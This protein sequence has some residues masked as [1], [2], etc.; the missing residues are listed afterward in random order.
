MQGKSRQKI[1]LLSISLV[2][3]LCWELRSLQ[4]APDPINW[5]IYYVRYTFFSSV[6]KNWAKFTANAHP[7][8][9]VTLGM[10]WLQLTAP[11]KCRRLPLDCMSGAE[12][13]RMVS[14]HILA[15]AWQTTSVT[16]CQHSGIIF[17]S[18]NQEADSEM[19]SSSHCWNPVSH[20]LER[21]T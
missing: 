21:G 1:L 7:L 3:S 9:S 17:A 5:K 15:R 13:Q 10:G 20:D 4:E 6:V 14:R 11:L 8:S 2:I 19:A 18:Q 16:P 12:L